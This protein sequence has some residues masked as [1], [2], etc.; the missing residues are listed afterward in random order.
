MSN[1]QHHPSRKL[2]KAEFKE[3]SEIKETL[4]YFTYQRNPNNNSFATE[5]H[6]Q[7]KQA[8]NG[9]QSLE[10]SDM[11]QIKCSQIRRQVKLIDSRVII[12]ARN[13]LLFYYKL[14]SNY[15]CLNHVEIKIIGCN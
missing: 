6:L 1:Y 9:L 5:K 15:F 7:I 8:P 2:F 12:E 10:T 13:P 3:I 4:F 14:Q 11:Q